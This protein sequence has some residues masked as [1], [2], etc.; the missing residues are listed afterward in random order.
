MLWYTR[1]V[2]TRYERFRSI[3]YNVQ[4][5]TNFP[6]LRAVLVLYITVDVVAVVVRVNNSNSSSH[7]VLPHTRGGPCVVRAT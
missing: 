3:L 5:W 6:F 2:F 1:G 4:I 7:R